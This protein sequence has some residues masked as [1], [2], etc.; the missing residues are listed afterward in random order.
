METLVRRCSKKAFNIIKKEALVQVFSCEFCE[1]S[2]N[3]FF[4]RTPPVTA[5]VPEVFCKKDVL[6]N[7]PKFAGKTLMSL[8]VCYAQVFSQK[9]CEMFTNNTLFVVSISFI[10][11]FSKELRNYNLQVAAVKKIF[12]H[13][14]LFCV[15]IGRHLQARNQEFFRAEGL[16]SN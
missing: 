9:F 11:C 13:Y 14:F 4:Y 1:V 15:I 8:K 2:K 7:F 10:F 12:L 6:K 5:S 16:F 3:T